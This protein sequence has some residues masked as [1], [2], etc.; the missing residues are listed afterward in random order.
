MNMVS[1]TRE[2]KKTGCRHEVETQAQGRGFVRGEELME[3]K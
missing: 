1:G 3:G 2:G